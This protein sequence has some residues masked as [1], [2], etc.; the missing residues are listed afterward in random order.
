MIFETVDGEVKKGKDLSKK[1]CVQPKDVLHF[2]KDL[3]D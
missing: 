1:V 3:R 2:P